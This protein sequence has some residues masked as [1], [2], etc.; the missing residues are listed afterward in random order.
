MKKIVF[1]ICSVMMLSIASQAQVCV[2]GTLTA[3]KKGYIL[4]DSATNFANACPGTYYEQILYIKAQK[5]TTITITTPISGIIVADIDS[6]VVD[7]NLAG[8]PSYLTA[9]SVPAFLPAAGPSLPK[10]NFPRLVI[11]GDSMAC[12]KISG[13]VPAGTTPGTISLDINLR[14]Y[15]S[16]LSSP[17][18]AIDLLIPSIYPGRKTDTLALIDYYKIEVFPNPCFPTSVSNTLAPV[19]QFQSIAPNPADASAMV[20]FQSPKS[21]TYTLQ[22][23]SLTGQLILSKTV[24]SETG[25]N[26]FVLDTSSLPN[27][28]YVSQLGND[29]EFATQ[30]L[31]I[32]R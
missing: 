14:V 1:T 13:N 32:Q 25:S 7:A 10:S 30:R 27:G 20:Q 26:R 18:L 21:G 28:I 5:D 6:F 11:P 24:Q 23:F 29:T 2:P 12:V 19:F 22:L 17:V 3:P 15:T 8:L 9:E 16:N 31:L 4:P